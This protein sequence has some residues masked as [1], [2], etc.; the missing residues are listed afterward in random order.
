LEGTLPRK[1]IS[2]DPKSELD[3][4]KS[5][6]SPA[7]WGTL[8]PGERDIVAAANWQDPDNFST[9]A[10][11]IKE[12]ASLLTTPVDEAKPTDTNWRD[13]QKN[14][15]LSYK[16]FG[17]LNAS[18][19]S[20]GNYVAEAGFGMASTILEINEFLKDLI[21]SYRNKLYSGILGWV[22]R[23]LGEGELFVLV[24]LDEEGTATVRCL[25][26]SRIGSGDQDGLITD[27]DD[28]TQTLFY[29]YVAGGGTDYIPD[30]RFIL[31]PDYMKARMQAAIK[32]AKNL[33]GFDP[34]KILPATKGSG[35][36]SKVGGFRRFVLHWKNLTGIHE[37]KR[38]IASLAT[39]LEWNNLYIQALK[40]ELDY[41]KA[42]CSYTIEFDF[43]DTP[44]GKIAWS[45]WKK[46]TDAQR[47]ATGLMSPLTPGSKIWT[48]PGMNI[49]IHAPQLQPLLRGSNQDL[50]NLSGAGAKTP[51]DLFQGQSGGSSYSSLK[52]SRPPLTAEIDALQ[53]KLEKFLRFE[54]L[55]CCMQAKIAMGGNV[56]TPA[57]KGKKLMPTYKAK[58]VDTLEKGNANI[59]EI[60][61]EPIEKVIIT[62]PTISLENNAEKIANSLMG[63]K[64][65][66]AYGMGASA[67]TVTKRMGFDGYPLE[68]R[69]QIIEQ[70]EYGAVTSGAAA[71]GDIEKQLNKSGA[72][73]KLPIKP[74]PEKE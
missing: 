53:S 10:I 18:V 7:E 47:A 61:V 39:T 4:A 55:R 41:K 27:P 33:Q 58:W 42:L 9:N 50:I 15:W 43:Q 37:Y 64:H 1:K 49:A 2:E 70:D 19:D 72:D 34:A 14:V 30:A 44:T 51:Q 11:T 66:G 48:M 71:E 26:P 56:L 6:F 46:M 62:F 16:T 21:Y 73:G 29:Q 59:I 67:A 45:V 3:F 32:V 24:A 5:L 35:K 12:M 57:G 36:Y 31:E 38:D 8:T 40:W 52:S 63:S 54:F 20:K 25:E 22:T 60:D 68:K 74:K 17:P 28:V 23:M 69:R 13:L 65:T